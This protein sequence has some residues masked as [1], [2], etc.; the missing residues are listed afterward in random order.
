[1]APR[2][3]AVRVLF[4]LRQPDTALYHRPPGIVCR[5]QFQHHLP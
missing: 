1:M 2:H 5:Q 4:L 3:R